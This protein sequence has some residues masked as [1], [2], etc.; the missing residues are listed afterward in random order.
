MWS[1]GG[2]QC[3]KQ[4][5]GQQCGQQV[6][7]RWSAPTDLNEDPGVAGLS[8]GRLVVVGPVDGCLNAALGGRLALDL[9][10]T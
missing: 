5:G 10:S 9:H 8:G 4:V 1:A 6:V 2:Q 7:S 3:D